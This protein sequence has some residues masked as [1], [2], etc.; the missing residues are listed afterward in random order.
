M[1]ANSIGIDRIKEGDKSSQK[2]AQAVFLPML[3]LA[4]QIAFGRTF[5]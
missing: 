2:T 1:Q 4:A 3:N 5:R